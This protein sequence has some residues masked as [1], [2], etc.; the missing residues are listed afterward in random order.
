MD[1]ITR[2]LCDKARAGDRAAYDRLFAVHESRLRLF[3]RARL[4]PRLRERVESQDV[5]QETFLAAHRDFSNFAFEDEGAFLK[6]IC[7]I[8][9]N[10]IRDLADHHGAAKRRP[11]APQFPP[12]P[13]T[14]PASAL[15]RVEDRERL[16]SALERLSEDHR[17][18]LLLRFFEG[19]AC[20]EVGTR[21]ERSPEAVRCLTA[22]ALVELGR[23]L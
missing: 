6:Y 3:I 4:G 15:D 14:G 19:L 17:E 8:A 22:R 11:E 10:R 12:S 13:P 23:C 2:S 16:A 5:V 1:S 9:E 21:M 7:R 18:V 20:R